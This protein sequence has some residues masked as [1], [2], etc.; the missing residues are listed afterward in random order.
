[1]FATWRFTVCGLRSSARAITLLLSPA[2]MC[3]S[4]SS[5]VRHAGRQYGAQAGPEQ[6]VVALRGIAAAA[7][8]G[9]R[10]R[11]LRQALEHQRIECAALGERLRGVDPVA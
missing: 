8:L 6:R 7:Q 3:A 4:T 11:S 10:T 2:A 1:M 9:Q 5:V